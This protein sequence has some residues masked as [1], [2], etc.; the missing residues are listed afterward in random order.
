MIRKMTTCCR[1]LTSGM[2]VF[3][4][5]AILAFDGAAI[6][7]SALYGY[8]RSDAIRE[9]YC[10]DSI[11]DDPSINKTPVYKTYC[12]TST[13]ENLNN[14]SLFDVKSYLGQVS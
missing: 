12:N 3:L 10:Q 14:T 5:S 9:E 13:P 2:P 6:L 8:Y 11:W 7:T 1:N 4:F